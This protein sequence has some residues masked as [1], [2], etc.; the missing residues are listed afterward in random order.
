MILPTKHIPLNRSLL[1]VG[2]ELLALLDREST[3]SGLWTALKREKREDEVP[4]DWFVLALDLLF[5]IGAIE[6]ERGLLKPSRKQS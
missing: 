1:G 2:A 6:F 4:F 3:V 5:G